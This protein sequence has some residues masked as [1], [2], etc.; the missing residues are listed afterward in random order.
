MRLFGSLGQCSSE[1]GFETPI[2][3]SLAAVA[4]A[5]VLGEGIGRIACISFGC[6][7]GMPVE[8]AQGWVQS[9]SRR[10]YFVFSGSTKNIAFAS[11]LEGVPA[12][13][14]QAMTAS[15]HAWIALGGLGLLFA[16]LYGWAGAVAIV[17]SQA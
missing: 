11:N 17:T 14:V 10:H 7:Y 12:V 2:T 15:L 16:G 6:C 5:Y 4:I 3:A 1:L 13:P 8:R 9:F